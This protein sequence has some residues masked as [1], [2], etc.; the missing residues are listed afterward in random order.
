MKALVVVIAALAVCAPAFGYHKPKPY[1]LARS[2]D[3]CL[4][5]G[6]NHPA[7]AN[8]SRDSMEYYYHH[9]PRKA[10]GMAFGP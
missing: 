2:Y 5:G 4:R 9:D 3:A 10:H 6:W 7:C 1:P 8:Y